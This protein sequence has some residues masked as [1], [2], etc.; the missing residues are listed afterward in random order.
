MVH[1]L[2]A[3][4]LILATAFACQEAGWCPT[5]PGSKKNEDGTEN[6]G[7]NHW[8]KDCPCQCPETA[9]RI[10]A[11]LAEAEVE[12]DRVKAEAVAI[13]Q[14]IA[15]AFKDASG[16]ELKVSIIVRSQPI[17]RDIALA[18]KLRAQAEEAG[19]GFSLRF[20]HE[21]EH[22][23][24]LAGAWNLKLL[25]PNIIKEADEHDWFLCIDS[26][27][28]VDFGGIRKLLSAFDQ[29]EPHLL[30]RGLTMKQL[31]I[32]TLNRDFGT[33][34]QFP[35]LPSGL[36]FSKAAM[37]SVAAATTT[38]G[39]FFVNHDHE[40]A[41]FLRKEPLGLVLRSLEH[42]CVAGE[43]GGGAKG[44]PESERQCVTTAVRKSTAE[45]ET[46]VVGDLKPQEVLI[47]VKT[48]ALFHKVL[49]T[50]C[51]HRPYTMHCTHIL[52]TLLIHPVQTAPSSHTAHYTHPFTYQSR[53]SIIKDTW[54]A[55]GA[56]GK[57]GVD[58][59]YL[60]D[61]ADTSP[62]TTVDL[63]KVL[64]IDGMYCMCC[65]L[66]S[67]CGPHQGVGGGGQ[68]KERALRQVPRYS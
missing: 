38:K 25:L 7:C 26:I 30:G 12:A 17:P 29:N 6:K 5:A 43:K 49:L 11:E 9:K 57:A 47:G 45:I 23:R 16:G 58:I 34:L 24:Q 40:L 10:N 18:K 22:S 2:L 31:T 35:Y 41:N 60:S 39:D 50:D 59:V 28:A 33:E 55:E 32:V 3:L 37:K 51:T 13:D 42:F 66:Y 63:T 68:P 21:L 53:L 48:C 19:G 15:D 44:A 56:D 27:T 61:K 20:V 52:Y 8:Y 14:R 54:G 64:L 1:K 46:G 67:Y 62:V 4:L 36:A 65:M